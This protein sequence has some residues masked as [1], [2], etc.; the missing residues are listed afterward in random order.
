[1]FN[2]S[3]AMGGQFAQNAKEFS[4]IIIELGPNPLKVKSKEQPL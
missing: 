2:L 4:E 3:A 1:M